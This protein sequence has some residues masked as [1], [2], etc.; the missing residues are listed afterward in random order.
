MRLAL[1]KNL[2]H[3]KKIAQIHKKFPVYNLVMQDGGVGK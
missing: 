3:K 2:K 1:K